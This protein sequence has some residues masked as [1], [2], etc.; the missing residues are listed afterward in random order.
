MKK[1][2]MQMI[3]DAAGV[4]RITV[5]KVFNNHPGVSPSLQRHIIETAQQMDYPLPETLI[6]A[7]TALPANPT[8]TINTTFSVVIS[9]PDTSNFW[10]S[11]IHE[12]AKESGKKNIS[13]LYTYIPTEIPDDY[14]LPPQLTN[15]SIQGIIV[16]NIY[17]TRLLKLL[18][19]LSLPKVFLDLTPDF[20]A[21]TLAGDLVLLGGK[22]PVCAITEDVIHHGKRNIG[23]IGDI[24][25]AL[26]NR[27]R[28][29]GY[30]EAMKKHRLTINP[31]YCFTSPIGVENY[32]SA[33]YTY[34]SSLKSL[35]D[36]FICVSDFVAHCAYKFLT[37]H[38]YI[39]PEDIL[40]TGYDNQSD[41]IEI[42]SWLPTVNVNTSALGSRLF[43]QL[44]YRIANPDADYET[45]LTKPQLLHHS[46]LT[47]RH[48][49]N[50]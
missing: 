29:E 23:F 24:H 44:E 1:P 43:H 4:S 12:I 6:S 32:E 14:V 48:S 30:L 15:G 42:H 17:N 19:N 33:I 27:M 46:P 20:P 18:N 10:M 13:L 21:E 50:T 36:A 47:P 9:R 25:Y 3:A 8:E 45:I 7:D 35:P 31:E 39:I 28:Y 16:L 38:D 5:W 11:M 37:T 2:T 26:T 41:F 34:L 40:L 22:A 49:S